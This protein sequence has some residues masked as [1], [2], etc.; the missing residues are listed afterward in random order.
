MF[1][2]WHPRY[3]C[4]NDRPNKRPFSEEQKWEDNMVTLSYHVLMGHVLCGTK[5][6]YFV[7]F[8]IR[9]FSL[10]TYSF[11]VKIYSVLIFHISFVQIEA[12]SVEHYKT[13]TKGMEMK[14]IT[15]QQ[16]INE[17]VCVVGWKILSPSFT[18]QILPLTPPTFKSSPK[19]EYRGPLLLQ[20]LFDVWC[21]LKSNKI[22][23]PQKIYHCVMWFSAV[24]Q[25][26]SFTPNYIN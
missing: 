5:K 13:L 12:R 7:L 1:V 4:N 26:V 8:S 18:L 25:I 23:I 20:K 22:T 16:K 15:L 3:D 2:L 24:S 14:V 6:H 10:N 17:Q 9:T 19:L 11:L 21:N